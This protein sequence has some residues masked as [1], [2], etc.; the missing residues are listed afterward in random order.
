MRIAVLGDV[1][2]PIYHVGDEA[3]THAAVH[4]LEQ[5]GLSDV[6]VL[7]RNP[8]DSQQRF[9]CASAPSLPFPWSPLERE[10]YFDAVVT[11]DDGQEDARRL[12]GTLRTCDALLIAGGGNLNS[13]YGWLLFERAAVAATA[14]KLGLPV[15]ISGQ[16]LG[17]TLVRRDRDVAA[18]LV[19]NAVV[20]GAREASTLALGR[21]LTDNNNVVP[22]LDDASFYATASQNVQGQLAGAY[23]AATFASGT[24]SMPPEM[25][26]KHVAA[27]LDHASRITGLPIVF[28]PH[29]AIEGAGDGDEAMHARIAQEM[30][31]ENVELRPITDAASTAALTA[32][33]S[34]VITSRY[35]PAVFATDA[36]LPC[37]ALAVEDYSEIRLR[38]TLANWGLGGFALSLPDL[39]GSAFKEA[40]TEAWNRRTEIRDHLKAAHPALRE[41]H[42]R[43][44]DAVVRGLNGNA[45]EP[46]QLPTIPELAPQGAWFSD[47]GTCIFLAQSAELAH[48]RAEREHLES[49][50]EGQR[51]RADDARAELEGW[52]NSR[53]FKAI[54]TVAS[55]KARVLHRK[56]HQ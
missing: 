12:A 2:Q 16:T 42:D 22:C 6:V 48:L 56:E 35:H 28:L 45:P 37:V 32:G 43:W 17:P 52:F 14:R 9:G 36:L 39:V 34:M 5:R 13:M 40:I 18:E 27:S 29:M 8:A 30:K 31:S 25:F 38:G 26:I 10:S 47:V 4:E 53:S 51:R 54:R 41:H 46:P 19:H 20:F 11:D 55:A 3:M 50:L 1:G 7:S 23:I 44:W 21:E 49:Q 15:V 33:A 24:G